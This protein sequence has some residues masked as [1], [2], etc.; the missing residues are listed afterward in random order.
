MDNWEDYCYSQEDEKLRDKLCYAI[1]GK[2]AFRRFKDLII[3][4][5]LE[6]D[7]D[8]YRFKALCEIAREWCEFNNIEYK[9]G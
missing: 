5:G 9:E 6:D 3:R 4:Y 7:W 1:D 8:A 2:G